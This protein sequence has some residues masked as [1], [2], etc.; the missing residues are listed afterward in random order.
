MK[1]TLI[2]DYGEKI[3]FELRNLIRLHIPVYRWTRGRISHVLENLKKIRLNVNKGQKS[4]WKD[5]KKQIKS[6]F[7][8][9]SK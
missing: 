6:I 1:I 7:I 3:E 2:A 4:R 9:I 8:E 5:Q